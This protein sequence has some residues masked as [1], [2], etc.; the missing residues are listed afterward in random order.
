MRIKS[1]HIGG[2][3]MLLNRDIRFDRDFLLFCGEN[4]SGKTTVLQ[5]I[6]MMLYGGNTQLR[7][8]YRPLSG[9]TMGGSMVLVQDKTEYQLDRSFGK[10]KSSDVTVLTDLSTGKSEKLSANRQ[11][12]ELL[13]QI[14]EDTFVRSCFV[15]S[16]GSIAGEKGSEEIRSK[17]QNLISTGTEEISAGMVEKRL[18]DAVKLLQNRSENGGLITQCQAKID[19]LNLQKKESEQVEAEYAKYTAQKEQLTARIHALEQ[20]MVQDV[21][22]KDDAAIAALRSRL[23]EYANLLTVDGE[24]VNRTDLTDLRTQLQDLNEQAHR[25]RM[26]HAI[27]DEDAQYQK[28]KDFYLKAQENQKHAEQSH[29]DAVAALEQAKK[30]KSPWV[31]RSLLLGG[32]LMLIGLILLFVK[33]LLAL[34]FAILGLGLL[35]VGLILKIR[36][37]RKIEALQTEAFLSEQHALSAKVTTETMRSSV[38]QLEAV[39]HRSDYDLQAELDRLSSRVWRSLRKFGITESSDAASRLDRLIETHDAY[40]ECKLRLFALEQHLTPTQAACKE[41]LQQRN[42]ELATLSGILAALPKP[43]SSAQIEEELTAARTELAALQKKHR[44]LNLAMTLLR[45]SFEEMQ[46]QYGGI[47]THETNRYLQILTGKHYDR[48]AI[49]RS[50]RLQ[51]RQQASGRMT[52]DLYFSAGTADQCYLALRLAIAKLIAAQSNIPLPLFFDDSLM[53]YDDRRCKA[54]MELIDTLVST[55][56]FSQAVFFTCHKR[57]AEIYKELQNKNE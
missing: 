33:L 45:E 17:L 3:G 43:R 2:F 22:Q 49:D 6:R 25:Y 32:L 1:V 8:H 14:G 55:G 29:A 16:V 40:T 42:L 47:L 28:A 24:V 51:A 31:L 36:R 56:E 11:P 35:I 39:M 5:F 44:A 46:K 10:S 12:G 15:E 54:A 53:Q 37:E 57:E 18:S 21:A 52:A 50:F 41:E 34:P 19:A 9:Q 13:L 38:L 48:A 20:Q 26:S 7:T 4:E 23:A 30:I 27:S